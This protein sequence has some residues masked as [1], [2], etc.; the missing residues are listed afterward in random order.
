M[1]L[2]RSK[3]ETRTEAEFNAAAAIRNN[4]EN[5]TLLLLGN[6]LLGKGV[7]LHAL[8]TMLPPGWQAKRLLVEDTSFY[9]WYYGMRHLFSIGSCPDEVVLMLSIKQLTSK[10]IRGEY[11]A[12]RLLSFVDLPDLATDLQLHPTAASGQM[13]GNISDF[14]GTRVE[15][16]K[17]V[18]GRLI[19]D[20]GN[21]TKLLIPTRSTSKNEE[22]DR[23]ELRTRFEK[24]KQLS[25]LKSIRITLIIAPESELNAET[26]KTVCNVASSVDFDILAPLKTGE[27]SKN[28]FSDSFHMNRNGAAKFTKAFAEA[29]R[30]YLANED[31]SWSGF[32]DNK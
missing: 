13:V 26:L 3:I 12:N 2:P 7:D 19:P 9:D 10:S 27:F 4:G 8:D 30:C 21:L 6:S 20:L 1:I 18:L 22:L 15:I 25:G 23:G 29:L 11:S 24:L 28:D 5:H 31:L 14:Y 17:Q 32:G 16:R